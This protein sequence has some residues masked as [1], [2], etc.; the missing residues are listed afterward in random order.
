MFDAP[1]P[2]SEERR[3]WEDRKRESNREKEKRGG[4]IKRVMAGGDTVFF[5]L[6]LLW[7]HWSRVHWGRGQELGLELGD[8]R[9]GWNWG[10]EPGLE[11]VFNV[12]TGTQPGSMFLQGRCWTQGRV[13][14]PSAGY[15]KAGHRNTAGG[16][17][18]RW[19]SCALL[20]FQAAETF[21]PHPD[22]HL[23]ARA[24]HVLGIHWFLFQIPKLENI[25]RQSWK[26]LLH[27]NISE[28]SVSENIEMRCWG[29][30]R[31]CSWLTIIH[32]RAT[33]TAN[34]V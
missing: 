27:L 26:N 2:G 29:E 16:G 30:N 34:L 32:F 19:L 15:W 13:L 6:H 11:D 10:I 31:P 18:N 3:E 1:N 7:V 21:R 20:P 9:W 8:R 25:C 5:A 4:V 22:K 23:V 33:V 17:P 14:L 28:Q 24:F 12:R